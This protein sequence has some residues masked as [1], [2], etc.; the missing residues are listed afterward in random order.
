MASWVSGPIILAST[1][2]YGT[3]TWYP[4]STAMFTSNGLI[5][6]PG[7]NMWRMCL[8][9]MFPRQTG[10][11]IPGRRPGDGGPR[12]ES[13]D[14]LDSQPGVDRRRLAGRAQGVFGFFLRFHDGET[15][16]SPRTLTHA[17]AVA[18]ADPVEYAPDRGARIDTALRLGEVTANAV[19]QRAHALRE[20]RELAFRDGGQ[21]LHQGQVTGVRSER[22]GKRR[23]GGE[24]LVFGR[25]REP[26]ARFVEHEHHAPRRR[27]V[28]SRED[29]WQHARPAR[30]AIDD[31]TAAFEPGDTHARARAA[32]ERG[33]QLCCAHVEPMQASKR[34]PDSER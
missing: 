33:R 6:R 18:R 10:G 3:T 19:L 8:R 13:A 26:G 24:R 20:R 32:R 1:S 15:R 22:L 23:Q 7:V 34:V 27:E 30:T 29:V 21:D 25:P 31:Q 16:R 28:E 5:C 12:V 4:A 11:S 9:S 17:R 2:V 14:Y